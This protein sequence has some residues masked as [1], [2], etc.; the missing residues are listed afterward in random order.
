MAKQVGDLKLYDLRELA[1][2]LGTTEDTLRHYLREGKLAG[3]K[4]G[5]KWYVSEDG[6]REYFTRK[7]DKTAEQ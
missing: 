7:Q 3:Q 1:E 4:I 2:M 5:V 6:L